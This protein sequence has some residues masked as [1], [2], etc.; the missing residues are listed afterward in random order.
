MPPRTGPIALPA[1]KAEIQ[2]PMAIERCLG[3]SNI[4]KISDRVDG[5]R[6]A[7]AMPSSA[8][9]PMSI[10]GVVEKAATTDTAPK[11]AAPIIRSFRRPIRSPSVP[12]VTRKPATMKP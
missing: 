11:A 3:S 2:T 6:V 4:A 10:S 9:L 1:E 5:A 8:R 12:I 7:P